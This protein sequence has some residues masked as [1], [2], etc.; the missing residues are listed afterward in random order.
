MIA[1][2]ARIQHEQSRPNTADMTSNE[3]MKWRLGRYRIRVAPT[4]CD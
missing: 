1:F 3:R 2:G 4:E